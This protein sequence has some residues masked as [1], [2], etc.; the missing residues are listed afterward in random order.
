LFGEGPLSALYNGLLLPMFRYMFELPAAIARDRQSKVIWIEAKSYYPA[1]EA[2]YWRT[3][4]DHIDAAV[5]DIARGFAAG[6]TVP[7]SMRASYHGTSQS[8]IG[9]D[10][11]PQTT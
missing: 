3:S 10:L 5:E 6:E 9:E 2:Y 1:H 4:K 8:W 11:A 7:R